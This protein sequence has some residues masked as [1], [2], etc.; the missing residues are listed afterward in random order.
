MKQAV[1]VVS[2]GT[3]FT[4]VIERCILPVENAIKDALK[5]YDFFRAFTSKTIIKK[6]EKT[7]GIH[8]PQ[9][10]AA[11]EQII[12]EGYE[13]I[14]IQPTH[15]MPGIEYHELKEQI[16][17]FAA[18]YPDIFIIVG[19]PLLY[20]NEDYETVVRAMSGFMPEIKKNEALIL[21]GH[22]TPH[23]S[24]AA[25]FEL[26]YY[27]KK[28]HGSR[29]YI[30]CVEAPP[31]LSDVIDELKVSNIHKVHLMPLMLVAGDHAK[32]DMAGEDEDSWKSILEKNGFEV[33]TCLKGLG[34]NPKILEIYKN[35][36]LNLI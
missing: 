6:L 36:V 32:K 23:F 7:K 17:A 35:K 8:I 1:L 9:P 21:M 30:A 2:F 16:A 13:K 28:I 26:Q 14:V 31:F 11:L 10:I 25:Y 34:E 5:E 29:I 12:R 15:I 20:E 22:G 27:M 33:D 4:E 24:N 19:Q 18:K 3:G